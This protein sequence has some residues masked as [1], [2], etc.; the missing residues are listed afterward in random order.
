MGLVDSRW[1]SK[2]NATHVTEGNRRRILRPK[3]NKN[4]D[5]D[6]RENNRILKETGEGI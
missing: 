2:V 3:Y 6:P 5:E 1:S 4:E